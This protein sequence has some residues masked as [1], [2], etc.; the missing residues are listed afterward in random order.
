MH[1]QPQKGSSVSHTYENKDCLVVKTKNKE[2]LPVL[3]RQLFSDKKSAQRKFASAT[4][5]N[6]V[7]LLKETTMTHQDK[8]TSH[9]MSW[10]MKKIVPQK[11]SSR[12]NTKNE[13]NQKVS[14][15]MNCQQTHNALTTQNKYRCV[16]Q[17]CQNWRSIQ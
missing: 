8:L 5:A 3:W 14:T 6:P 7:E 10:K 9:P 12:I 16:F 4:I 15:P 11:V 13:Q 1:Y 2:K 17:R